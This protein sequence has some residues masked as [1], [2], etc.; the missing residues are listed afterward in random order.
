MIESQTCV[1]RRADTA[2]VRAA[3]RAGDDSKVLD[4]E[5]N[6]PRPGVGKSR[7]NHGAG[8]KFLE[9]SRQ[10]RRSRL[11]GGQETDIF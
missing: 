10:V 6:G 8:G 4:T 5:S 7:P 2:Q 3:A 9:K 11:A 1:T